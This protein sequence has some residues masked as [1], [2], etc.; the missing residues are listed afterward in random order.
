[1]NKF[2]LWLISLGYYREEGSG[3]WWYDNKVVYGAELAKK[4]EEFKSLPQ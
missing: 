2:Q 4:L 1:M 3:V